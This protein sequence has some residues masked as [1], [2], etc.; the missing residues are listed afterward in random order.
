[1][2]IFKLQRINLLEFRTAR[3]YTMHCH[4]TLGRD[5]TIRDINPII[6]YRTH[7]R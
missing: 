3:V 6:Q 5:D 2:R 4:D 7:R 1:M